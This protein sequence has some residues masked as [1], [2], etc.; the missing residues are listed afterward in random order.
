MLKSV[1]LING[2]PRGEKSCSGYLLD[3]VGQLLNGNGIPSQ[4][5][6]I[7]AFQKDHSLK[8]NLAT[9]HQSD[10]LVFAFPLYIDA[11]PSNML[12][13]L[14]QLDD[15]CHSQ[16]AQPHHPRVYVIVNNG[17]V[18]G[19]QNKNALN[20]MRHFTDALGYNWRFG[21]GIGGGE[22]LRETQNTIPLHS[23][24]KKPVYQGLCRLTQDIKT[25]ETAC[26]TNIFVNPQIPKTLF[27]LIGSYNW[28]RQARQNHLKKKDLYARP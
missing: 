15:Y 14:V 5:I 9:I 23:W 7:V 26:V 19:R 28:I 2:S 4:T 1:C 22:F 8:E 18:E 16:P 12:D 20:I 25:A 13:V 3:E 10:C 17:F 6:H 27:K 21:I 11:L 24:V